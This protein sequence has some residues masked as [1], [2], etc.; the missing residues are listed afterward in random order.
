M[1][2]ILQDQVFSPAHISGLQLWLDARD[3]A[4]ISKDG[5]NRLLTWTDKSGNARNFNGNGTDSRKPTNATFGQIDL[6][7]AAAQSMVCSSAS[8]MAFLH[9][10][11]ATI[12]FAIK[13]DGNNQQMYLGCG[14]SA[15]SGAGAIYII[16]D[17][18]SVPAVQRHR[19]TVKKASGVTV[20]D[21]GGGARQDT[22]TAGKKLIA[23]FTHSSSAGQALY[24]NSAK[25]YSAAIATAF[26]TTA[27]CEHAYIFGANVSNAFPFNGAYYEILA[28]NRVLTNAELGKVWRYLGARHGI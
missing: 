9:Q 22:Y 10:D 24:M 3:Q 25:L 14:Y 28:W 15:G 7:S 5:S 21:S 4:T 19:V 23:S 27:N 11:G 13:N 18:D 16:D 17:R 6:S 2:L 26:D 8:Q 1:K 20:F 12:I